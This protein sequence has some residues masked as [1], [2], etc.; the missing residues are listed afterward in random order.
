MRALLLVFV[1]LLV[2]AS[3]LPAPPHVA[4][5]RSATAPSMAKDADLSTWEGALRITEFGMIMPDDK[6]VNRWPT[7][8]HVLWGPDALY[9][10]IEA[11][12][13]EPDK[14]RGFLHRRDDFSG[15]QDF[16][17]IDLDPTGKGQGA[18]RLFVTPLGGQFDGLLS[19]TTGEDYSYDLLWDSVGLKTPTGYLVKLRVPYSSLRRDPAE[20]GLRVL[21][22]IPRERRYGVAWPPMSRDIQC[23][24]CQ[25]GRVAGAPQDQAGAPFLIIPT[26]SAHRSQTLDVDPGAPTRTERRLGMD[27]RYAG[28]AITL[29]GTYRPDFNAVDA[30]V[31][32]LQV[33]SRFKV[34][35][36]EKRP[37]FLEGMDLLGVQ[38]AQR[39]FF[40]RAIADP[41]YGLKASGTS[42]LANWTVLH[43]KD[44]GGGA[45]LGT[46]GGVGVEGLPTRDTA[47]AVRF[48][49]DD[50][51]SG[52]SILGTDKL[53]L[54]GPVGSGGQSGGF[55]LDKVLGSEWRVTAS[56]IRSVA[57]LPQADGSTT[58]TSGTA[59]S[60]EVDW[61]T[62]RWSTFVVSQATSPGLV[63]ASGFTDLQGY[64]QNVAGL[65]F[66]DN[67][68]DGFVARTNTV[69]R[70]RDLT[71]WNGR[72]LD[73]ALTL[74]SFVEVLGRWSL[75]LVS[76]M[77]GRT[78]GSDAPDAA[79]AATRSLNLTLQ[80][81]RLSWAQLSASAGWGRTLD[82]T[83][84]V[85]ARFHNRALRSSGSVASISYSLEGKLFEL[86]RESDGATLVRAR[87]VVAAATWQLPAHVYVKVQSFVVRYDGLEADGVDKYLKALLGWQPNAFTG[88]YV[89]WSGQ[90]RRDPASVLPQER[91]VERGIFAKVAY[92]LQF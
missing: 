78:W 58:S 14:V 60:V 35:Y 16:V 43:A 70:A 2:R 55:Y 37:F 28:R 47:A 29:E 9:V 57:H 65:S 91:M 38:G 23:D 10:A 62:R 73:R 81:R 54:G 42:S 84:G 1:C 39:Q 22:I 44:E 77:A 61:N 68:N 26:A 33:N 66:H 67:W 87:Q 45:V 8:A 83:S 24:L 3:E 19:D 69:L 7:T 56:G 5:P 76:D 31:D 21:R 13:P 64:R 36:P 40:S 86:D 34:F 6:G 72:P 71:W 20:W 12:D 48:R 75:N 30:D 18:I 15:D 59:T 63:L 4:I 49:L 88:A 79:E 85:P 27:L 51:G 25:M 53:L 32:P 82:Y 74:D 46:A 80:W 89:G 17:G 11:T 41:L 90:R 50:R 92:A 52:A